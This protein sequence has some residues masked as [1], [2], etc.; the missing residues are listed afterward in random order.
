MNIKIVAVSFLFINSVLN[1]YGQSSPLPELNTTI[2]QLSTIQVEPKV[3]QV[4]R[5]VYHRAVYSP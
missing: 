1:V 2:S 3:I 5:L 4:S